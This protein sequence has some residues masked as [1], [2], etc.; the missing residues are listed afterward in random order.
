MKILICGGRDYTDY[1]A[2]R[3]Y[4]KDHPCDLV[5][6]GG[7]YGADMLADRAAK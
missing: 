6:H 2:I 5:I 7:Y 1:G 3:Q 4:L